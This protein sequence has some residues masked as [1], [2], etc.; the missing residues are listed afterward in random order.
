MKTLLLG[1]SMTKEEEGQGASTPLGQPLP[2]AVASST[3]A[4][5]LPHWEAHLYDHLQ[6]LFIIPNCNILANM[7]FDAIYYFPMMYCVSMSSFEL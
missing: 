7:M 6:Q 2:C 3:P 1:S 5:R 4:P